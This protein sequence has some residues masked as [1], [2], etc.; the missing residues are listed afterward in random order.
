[1]RFPTVCSVQGGQDWQC[2]GQPRSGWPPCAGPS[3]A[4]ACVHL[5]TWLAG[6]VFRPAE[7]CTAAVRSL[8]FVLCFLP[9]LINPHHINSHTSPHLN[10]QH[11][12]LQS[13]ARLHTLPTRTKP[14]ASA[15]LASCQSPQAPPP[16]IQSQPVSRKRTP[17]ASFLPSEDIC[18]FSTW[19]RW[20][21]ASAARGRERVWCDGG[22]VSRTRTMCMLMPQRVSEPGKGPDNTAHVLST[23]RRPSLCPPPSALCA[24][25]HA[26]RPHL[27][28]C[29]TSSRYVTLRWSPPCSVARTTLCC[30]V[31]FCSAR[32]TQPA[33]ATDINPRVHAASS[34]FNPSHPS[35]PPY[36]APSLEVSSLFL[37]PN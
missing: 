7:I 29:C 6:S 28:L 12:Q 23:V 2:T 5:G 3:Y 20:P 33:D 25:F 21:D 19:P 35:R 18:E 17:L 26:P 30:A 22:T 8:R 31:P 14:T 27:T 37:E 36:S 24:R 15:S 16:K 32:H 10:P 34:L 11:R 9:S 4:R 1:M 13:H